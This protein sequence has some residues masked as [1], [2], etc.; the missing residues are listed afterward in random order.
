MGNKWLGSLSQWSLP[1]LMS[2]WVSFHSPKDVQ[3]RCIGY[4]KLSL[5]VPEKAPECDEHGFFHNNYIAMLM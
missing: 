3:V 5:S 4:A 2:V 1:I